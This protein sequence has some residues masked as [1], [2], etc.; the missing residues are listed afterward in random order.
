MFTRSQEAL[1]E[2]DQQQLE[3]FFNVKEA[4]PCY[5][6]V[7]GFTALFKRQ[8]QEAEQIIQ[9]FKLWLKGALNSGI[10]ELVR[11]AKGLS[12]DKAAIEAALTLPWS[13]GQT[14][15]K[16]TKLKLIKRSMYGRANFDLLRQ[17]VLLAT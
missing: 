3:S 13:N 14:E 1:T 15:G 9:A 17:R 7:Q 4:K 10:S 5:E 12:N 16:I 2:K 11:F 6:L 8:D